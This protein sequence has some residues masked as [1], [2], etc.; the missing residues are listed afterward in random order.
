[1]DT[2]TQPKD[3]MPSE[4]PVR[5]S[6]DY[7]REI[8]HALEECGLPGCSIE[9][10]AQMMNFTFNLV[11]ENQEVRVAWVGVATRVLIAASKLMI[12]TGTLYAHLTV[13]GSNLAK[14]TSNP[15]IVDPAFLLWLRNPQSFQDNG[16]AIPQELQI[17]EIV[18]RVA[19]LLGWGQLSLKDDKATLQRFARWVGRWTMKCKLRKPTLHAM[20]LIRRNFPA[21]HIWNAFRIS[22]GPVTQSPRKR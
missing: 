10:T 7:N 19:N 18:E 5:I 15:E 6:A 8:V 21:P 16:V 17:P 2:A 9:E 11:N 12:I 22:D 13:L 14:V 3:P 4:Q 20:Q 1:M